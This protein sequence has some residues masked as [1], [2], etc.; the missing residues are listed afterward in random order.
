MEVL[1]A[2]ECFKE[3]R[4]Q[5]RH[6][7]DVL[8]FTLHCLATNFSFR[9]LGL[10]EQETE[11]ETETQTQTQTEKRNQEWEA[12]VPERWNSQTDVFT[13]YYKHSQSSFKF[14]MKSLIFLDY[15]VVHS[16]AIDD[17]KIFTL[18]LKVD[19]Y[20]SKPEKGL[21]DYENLLKLEKIQNL[22]DTFKSRILLN[23]LPG[24][25]PGFEPEEERTTTTST[26]P[27][28]QQQQQQR[29]QTQ[30]QPR[31][32]DSFPEPSRSP[33]PLIPP[34]GGGFPLPDGMGNLIGPNHPSFGD[35]LRIPP[36]RGTDPSFGLPQRLPRGAI[37]P[38]ARFDPFGPPAP[39]SF[40]PDPDSEPIPYGH[41]FL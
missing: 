29:Q 34:G 27:Q 7:H 9:F 4:V 11:T 38:G 21:T 10:T 5:F 40:D 18:P 6:R 39:F 22:E 1:R 13:F 25:K 17:G 28:L 26:N 23:L 3:K 2:V 12:V 16:A 30:R 20:V 31:I 33:F 35:P 37:P 32:P 15:L 14:V 24:L 8:A 36:F 41:M 19:E